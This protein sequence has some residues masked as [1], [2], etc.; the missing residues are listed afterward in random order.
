MDTRNGRERIEAQGAGSA[1]LDGGKLAGTWSPPGGAYGEAQM[2]VW[3]VDERDG[4]DVMVSMSGLCPSRGQ[5]E[6][7]TGD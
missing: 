7:S 1:W 5:V 2:R 6:L 3:S 4:L